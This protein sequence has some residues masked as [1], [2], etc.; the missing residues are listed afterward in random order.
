MVGTAE[1]KF[2]AEDAA[3]I[4]VSGAWNLRERN[5][6]P[7]D[8]VAKISSKKSMASVKVRA[9]NLEAWDS[10]LVSFLVGIVEVCKAQNSSLDF[11][12]IPAGALKLVDLAETSKAADVQISEKRSKNPLALLIGYLVAAFANSKNFIEFLGETCSAVAAFFKRRV[13][14]RAQEFLVILQD[15]GVRALPIV[16]LISF[17]VGLIIAFIS[18]LELAQFGASIY[19]ADLVGI[20]MMREMGCIMTGVIMSGRTGAAFAATIG[21]MVVNDEVDA[22]QTTGFSSVNFLILPRIFALALMMPLLCMFSAFIGI[23]GGLCAAVIRTDLSITQYCMQTAN[24]VFVNDFL[25]G[26]AKGTFFG[27]LIA[28]IGCLKGLKCGRSAEDV[29]LATTAAVVTS[30]TAIIVADAAFA[31]I[32]ASIGV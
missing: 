23:F 32:F 25:V 12:G 17:L 22:L 28:I 27:M 4:T 15:V 1:L 21:T 7:T 20:S 5:R 24:A 10:S 19:V 9:V 13:R 18:I 6:S 11:D 26:I 14:I 3:E 2:E 8:C 31:V 30:I 29:G 16:A